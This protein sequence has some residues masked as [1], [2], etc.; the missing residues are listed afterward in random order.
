MF[1]F[2]IVLVLSVFSIISCKEEKTVS[3]EIRVSEKPDS[4]HPKIN[5]ETEIP[6][7]T[8][9]WSGNYSCNFLR[10]KE[11]SGDPRAWGM[12]R[13]KI[14]KDS[15]NFSLDTYVENLE[16]DLMILNE[17]ENEIILSLKNKKDSTFVIT[18]KNEK[19]LLKSNFID[20][21]VGE[22]EV[23]QLVKQ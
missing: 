12:M 21:T 10:L 23:Y 18:K 19:Y 13:I 16:R 14:N 3:K 1:K 15:T 6:A 17:N 9:S 11:E 8:Y 4:L 5:V 2:N 22:T 20:K 7:K